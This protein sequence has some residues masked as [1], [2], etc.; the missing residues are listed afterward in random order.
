MKI[1]NVWPKFGQK[2]RAKLPSFTA[3]RRAFTLSWITTAPKPKKSLPSNLYQDC[4]ECPLDVFIDCLVSAKLERLIKSGEASQKELSEAWQNIWFGYCDLSDSHEMKEIVQL[5][6][7]IGALHSKLNAIR[8]SVFIL[9]IK[10]SE[11][12][13]SVLKS[14]GFNYEFKSD[15]VKDLQNVINISKSFEIELL[16]KQK[17][18]EKLTSEGGKSTVKENYFAKMLVELT[19]YMGVMLKANQI[20]VTEFMLIKAKYDNEMKLTRQSME[21]HHGK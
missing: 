15:L 16:Q 12:S 19:K 13:I 7:K 10:P 8:L 11:H 4:N 3:F 9:T 6:K 2:V 14:L 18:Y 1:R 20:T 5:T 21:K 17:Q